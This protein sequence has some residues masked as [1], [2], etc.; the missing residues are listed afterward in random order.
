MCVLAEMNFTFLKW[1]LSV[2]L[3]R[4]QE[5]AQKFKILKNPR[6]QFCVWISAK[7][8]LSRRRLTFPIIQLALNS[9][10]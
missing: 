5:K 3:K 6:Y 1:G 9:V 8:L 7:A 10:T 2:F 4:F